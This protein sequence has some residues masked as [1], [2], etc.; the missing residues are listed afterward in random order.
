MFRRLVRG[1]VVSCSTP[2]WGKRQTPNAKR[3]IP[4]QDQGEA[5]A[6]LSKKISCSWWD[7]ELSLHVEHIMSWCW[8][9]TLS[10]RSALHFKIII[11]FDQVLD[12]LR[13]SK[14]LVCFADL[15]MSDGLED[16]ENLVAPSSA[17]LSHLPLNFTTYI[18]LLQNSL[19]K[20]YINHQIWYFFSLPIP[21]HSIMPSIN[22]SD[23]S[24]TMSLSYLLNWWK[25]YEF[26]PFPHP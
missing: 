2:L 10:G 5:I 22:D 9:L 15:K 1:F 3:K 16:L 14:T 8:T 18:Y 12:G 11:K 4:T 24:R 17:Q 23:K 6:N 20:Q 7:G 26:R 19:Q 25:K 13:V 21:D